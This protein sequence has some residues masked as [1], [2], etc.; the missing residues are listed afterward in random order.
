MCHLKAEQAFECFK[1]PRRDLTRIMVSKG[2]LILL[3]CS[4]TPAIPA[5]NLLAITRSSVIKCHSEIHSVWLLHANVSRS[6][7]VN[8]KSSIIQCQPMLEGGPIMRE[9]L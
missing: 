8:G 2:E 5:P 6:Q 1:C 3:V 4:L 9:P 7:C